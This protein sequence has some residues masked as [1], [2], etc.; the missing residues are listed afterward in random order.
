MRLP[1]RLSV[2]VLVAVVLV[3]AHH[4]IVHG[5]LFDEPNLI[6]HEAIAAFLAGAGITLWGLGK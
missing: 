1:I 6:S 3:F 5:C 4:F 2:L